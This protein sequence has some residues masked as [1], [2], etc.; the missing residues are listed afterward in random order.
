MTSGARS[1]GE[2]MTEPLLINSDATMGHNVR[3]RRDAIT[4][5]F[6]EIYKLRMQAAAALEKHVKP[7]RDHVSDIKK[8]LR[9]AY[10]LPAKAINARYAAFELLRL[11]ENGGDDAMQDAIRELFEALPIGGTL[12]LADLADQAAGVSRG[13]GPAGAP[14]NARGAHR[15]GMEAAKAG[16]A[17]E[18]C[19]Y[20][21]PSGGLAIAWRNGWSE[22]W[23]QL[24]Q[25]AAGL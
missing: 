2:T 20:Q 19:P 16:R 1:D 12:N 3:A 21:K 13:S 15:A 23:Q 17:I 11:A 7:L 22:V 18:T 14:K 24:H 6:D 5:S 4:E 9:E 25:E 8:R 10:E